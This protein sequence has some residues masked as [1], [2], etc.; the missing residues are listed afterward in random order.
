MRGGCL[1]A[2]STLQL[3]EMRAHEH[4]R[5]LLLLLLL[6]PSQS[7]S[8]TVPAGKREC[9]HE[10]ARV[11]ER[12]AG[13]WRVL[14]VEGIAL[15]LD[16]A[17]TSP[18]DDHVYAAEGELRGSF[19]FSATSEGDYTFCFSNE[20][21]TLSSKDVAAKI[22]VGDPPDLIQLATSEQL[23]PVELRIKKLHESMI[24]VR[25]LQDQMKEQDEDHHKAS[26]TTRS[27]L[28]WFT[29]LEAVVLVAVSLW[30]IL[31]LKSFFEVRR[32]V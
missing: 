5:Y 1:H 15:D 32:V 6:T 25:D 24:T 4:L 28:L 26:R 19:A 20:R 30:Q 8:F 12:V 11:G 22:S 27:W 21:A 9:Y 10:T 2:G 17:V 16:V 18:S 31:Y 7:F 23:T 14:N 3:E 13:E 29:I